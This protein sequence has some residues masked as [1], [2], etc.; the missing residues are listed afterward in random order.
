MKARA[1]LLALLCLAAASAQVSFRYFYDGNGQ[2]FRV[3]DSSGNLV[4]YDYDAAGNPT[5][6]R[7]ST[8]AAGSLAI[9][10]IAPQRGGPNSTVTIYGQNFSGV[11]AGNTVMFNGVAATVIS[12]SATALVVQVPAAV[13]TGPVSLT[14][15]GAT[16]T[17]GSLNFT[18]PNIPT[19]TSISPA[20]GY[21]GQPVTV[22][23]QGTNLTG[24]SFE[25]VGITVSNV[26]VASSAQ[27]SF[28]ATVGQAIGDSVVVATNDFGSSSPV[29]SVANT[30][31]AFL[32]AGDNYS[33][34]RLAVFNTYIAPGTEPGVPA[35]ANA[36]VQTVSVFNTNI[37]DGTQ[38]GVPTG[39]HA[40]LQSFST[41]NTNIPLG[42]EPGVP[43]GSNFAFEMFSANNTGSGSLMAPQIS[44]LP[45]RS[46]P[47][48]LSGS[49]AGANG[50][51]SSA[52]AGQTVEIDI[53]TS[54]SFL[55]K[56]QF[57]VNGGVLA[58]S[59]IGWL[60]TFF[61]VPYGASSLTLQATGQTA[62]GQEVDSA[63]MVVAVTADSG[64][65]ISGKAVDAGGKPLARAAVTWQANG[66]TADYYQFN[67]QISGLPD[68]AGLQPVRTTYLSALNYPNPQQ[69]F[70]KDPMG[71]GLGPNYAARFHGKLLVETAGS[72]QFQLAADAGAQLRIDRRTVENA[73][74][75]ELT[76]GEHEV[77]VTYYESGG[78]S[79][80]QLLW[81]PPGGIEQI[82]PPGSWITRSTA[83]AAGADGRFQ[84]IVPA[85]LTGVQVLIANG[86][87]ELDQ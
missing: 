68:L 23:V 45:M 54:A 24:A 56:L 69:I 80:L 64:S 77:E 75:T 55:P 79:A 30:F 63:P 67:R 82:V 57:R 34:V 78:V 19:I 72:Y 21:Q 4:E 87:V 20:F 26:N 18:V 62:Y 15:N 40:A 66:L 71:I 9:L 13:T 70:G 76:V 16:A 86:S 81:T 6:I 33:V 58:S 3:L 41:F 39:S 7:R 8:V 84:V 32:P 46:S 36:A 50:N 37:P 49:G 65:V 27:A 28:T 83:N 61:T 10:N 35:G 22:T 47:G 17:S 44:I 59:S 12:A 42:S 25:L 1:A 53:G 29:A 74:I 31:H 60:K 2:L 52:I 85:V 43:T 51:L 11:A 48:A 38:P 73:A 5:Q 14:V